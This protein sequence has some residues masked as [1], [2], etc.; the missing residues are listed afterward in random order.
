MEAGNKK[1][2]G[3]HQ[4]RFLS[5]A[6]MVGLLASSSVFAMSSAPTNGQ[7]IVI[8][9]LANSNNVT[10]TGVVGATASSVSVSVFAIGSVTAC[11]GPTTLAYNGTMVVTWATGAT[12]GCTS[13]GTVQV[14]PLKTVGLGT[15]VYDATATAPAATAGGSVT[16]TAPTTITGLTGATVTP[17]NFALMILGNGLPSTTAA[18]TGGWTTPIAALTPIFDISNGSLSTTGIV[19]ASGAAGIKAERIMRRFGVTPNVADVQ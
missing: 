2:H 10:G 4:H 11:A 3:N 18:M 13:I 5:S 14:T 15:V 7:L 19:G 8:N 1:N 16:F 6:L 17:A 12:K 9:E